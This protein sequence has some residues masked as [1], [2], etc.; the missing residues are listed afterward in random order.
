MEE[1]NLKLAKENN[2]LKACVTEEAHKYEEILQRNI[3]GEYYAD[4]FNNQI[5]TAIDESIESLE[6]CL[7][8]FKEIKTKILIHK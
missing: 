6:G 3:K 2:L 5:I 8:A 4:I 1:K 7:K